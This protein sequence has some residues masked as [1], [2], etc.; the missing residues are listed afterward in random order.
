VQVSNLFL[1]FTAPDVYRTNWA[2]SSALGLSFDLPDFS[3][4]K[5]VRGAPV[6]KRSPRP[7]GVP[8]RTREERATKPYSVLFTDHTHGYLDMG[9][10]IL[11]CVKGRHQQYTRNQHQYLILIEQ[12]SGWRAYDFGVFDTCLVFVVT[13]EQSFQLLYVP[14]SD[15][16]LKRVELGLPR[17]DEADFG[18]LSTGREVMSIGLNAAHKGLYTSSPSPKISSTRDCVW[19]YRFGTSE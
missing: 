8:A 7:A 6:R 19:T 1:V 14:R 15:R 4:Q 17:W 3:Y 16:S 18:Q 10:R 5:P 9:L 12:K 2:N 11:R 13:A